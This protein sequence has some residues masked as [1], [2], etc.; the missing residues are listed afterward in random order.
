MRNLPEVT[1]GI[2]LLADTY[3]EIFLEVDAK[4]KMAAEGLSYIIVQKSS[5]GNLHSK[6]GV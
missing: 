3:C 1:Q 5:D 2:I 4:M 6:R